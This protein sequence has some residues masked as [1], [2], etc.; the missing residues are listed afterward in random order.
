[1][2][3]RRLIARNLKRIRL[4]RRLSQEALAL[5]ADVDRS[6]VSGLERAVRNPSVDILDRLADALS[7]KTAEFFDS[8]F[9]PLPSRGLPRGRRSKTRK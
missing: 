4:A 8:D 3:S 6:Y 1:M 5:E 7:A 9:G 2:Q